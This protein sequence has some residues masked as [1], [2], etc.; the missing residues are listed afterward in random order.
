[1][2]RILRW[3]VQS[4]FDLTQLEDSIMASIEQLKTELSDAADAIAE[5]KQTA[6]N[7]KEEIA[8][9][10]NSLDAKITE[11]TGL[12]G[13]LKNQV[14]VPDSLLSELADATASIRQTTSEIKVIVD[15]PPTT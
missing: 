7:E 3:L 12:I 13:Q 15:T 8:D 6:A 9:K 5:L 1:M 10:L 2:G 11:Q 4:I 14:E